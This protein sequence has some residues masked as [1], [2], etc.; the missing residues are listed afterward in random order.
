[1][2]KSLEPATIL[3]VDDTP[4]NL[5][6][7]SESL[8]TAGYRITVAIDGESAVDQAVFAPPDLILLDIM[9][10]GIDGFETCRR[11][12]SSSTTQSIPVLFMTALSETESKVKGFSLG[13]V[14]YITKPFQREEVLA[15][16]QVHMQICDLTQTLVQQNQLLQQEV[17]QRKQAETKLENTLTAL[18]NTQVQLVQKEKLSTLGELVAGIGHEISNPCNF[19]T[20]NLPA[21][22]TY[23]A[24]LTNIINLYQKVYPT[25]NAEIQ[26]VCEE[27]D[28]D[29]MLQDLSKLVA[30]MQLGADRIRELSNSLRNFARADQHRKSPV[31]L[32]KVIDGTLL[33][34]G[35]RLKAFNNR[36]TIEVVKH[37]G[38]IPILNCYAGQLGQVFMNLF[39]NAIDAIEDAN[40][41]RS[42]EEIVAQ[43]SQI[44]IRTFAANDGIKIAI[45]DNGL[46][47][48]KETCAHIFDQLFTT[49]EVG[50]GTGLG[51]AIA[52]QIIAE[53]HDGTIE[54]TSQ[55]GQGTE[56]LITLPL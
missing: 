6:V 17:E 39:A 36:P 32:H 7:L 28:L 42:Y 35:H 37:Y 27:V 48:S 53:K 50:R 3:I 5:E 2:L 52:Q 33:I 45:A 26:T 12:K 41:Q 49:K 14:D 8:A 4:E 43:P 55:I 1:M 15:R 47:M 44:T 38:D 40:R 54:V 30:S 23:I 9:M 34:L 18:Q 21:A 20:S 46:G 19:I 10:P 13:A 31:D 16:V 29:F 11:L 56:F 22:K 24:D 51:L 25:P